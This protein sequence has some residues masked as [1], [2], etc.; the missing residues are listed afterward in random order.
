MHPS[1]ICV[2]KQVSTNYYILITVIPSVDEFLF[3]VS[4]SLSLLYVYVY[5]YLKENHL[6]KEDRKEWGNLGFIST[7]H[8]HHVCTTHYLFSTYFVAPYV[9]NG[10]TDLLRGK[11]IIII[12]QHTYIHTCIH[13][14]NINHIRTSR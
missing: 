2:N 7:F 14:Y 8:I 4:L 9:T 13:A 3:L 5:V 10:R 6:R 12:N 11:K 1:S